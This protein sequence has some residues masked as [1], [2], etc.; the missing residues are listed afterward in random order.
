MTNKEAIEKLPFLDELYSLWLLLSQ[1][2]A[3][4]FKARHKRVGQY[5]HFNQAAALVSIWGHNGQATPAILSRHLFL[6]PH[7]VSELIIRMEKKGLVTKRRDK[8]RENI[9]RISITEKGREFC[10]R[11]VQADFIRQVMSS[12]SEEQREQLWKC[13]SILFNEALKELGM[14]AE[15]PLLDLR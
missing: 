10:S 5:V 9:V 3:A 15:P 6:E 12:L 14:E 13:L 7:S 11:T 4:V 2:R 8:E 1:T